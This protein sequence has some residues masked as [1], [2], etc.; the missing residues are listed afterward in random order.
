MVSSLL[1]LA[2]APGQDEICPRPVSRLARVVD[3]YRRC[4]PRSR[5]CLA[6]RSA[7]RTERGR[8]PASPRPRGSCSAPVV[9]VRQRGR[10]RRSRRSFALRDG[11]LRAQVL[12]GAA[13]VRSGANRFPYCDFTRHVRRARLRAWR[14]SST[15]TSSGTATRRPAM[16]TSTAFV[17]AAEST[18]ARIRLISARP[19]SPAQRKLYETK[20]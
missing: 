10:E 3:V 15:G 5:S 14:P 1:A 13:R 17:V 7:S 4:C 19:A 8:T 6:G 16:W 18:G 2:D 11:R 9:L 20:T 12:A